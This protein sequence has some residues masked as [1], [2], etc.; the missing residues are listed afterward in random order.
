MI[1]VTA[2]KSVI[3]K[4]KAS[5]NSNKGNKNIRNIAKLQA[6]IA[7]AGGFYCN[8][9]AEVVGYSVETIREWIGEFLLHGLGFLKFKKPTGRPPKLSSEQKK[10]LKQMIIDGPE[11]SGYDGGCWRTP[12]IQHLIQKTFHTKF[13]VKYLSEFLDQ[14]GLSYQKAKFVSDHKD[15]IKRKEWLMETWPKIMKIAN[16][17]GSQ[18]L[19]GDEAAFPQWG[20]LSYTW[21]PRG[22][23]PVVKTSGCRK[24]HKVF[25]LIDYK[26][27]CFYSKAIEGKFNSQ[28]Y[29][30]FLLEVLGK[31][32]GHLILIQDGAR[33]HTSKD[34]KEFFKKHEDRITVFQLPSYSPDYNP[35]EK[36]WKK[37]KQ[38]GVHLVYFPDFDSL[39]NKVNK[40]LG[41]FAD[42]AKEVLALFGFYDELTIGVR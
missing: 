10:K 40:M 17:K 27:G 21:A 7:A 24:G 20:S 32:K 19:F 12:M 41:V 22:Q 34:M 36:L 25:G 5:L 9:I 16:K 11:N 31:S 26:S 35:I 38:K 2:T 15:P 29:A 30:E 39:K 42:A 6:V 4:L 18:I 28:S 33:Y 3:K 8:E 37:I 13:S 14:I 23:Q 1:R